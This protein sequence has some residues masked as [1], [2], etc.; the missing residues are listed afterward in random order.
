MFVTIL[1]HDNYYW[2]KTVKMNAGNKRENNERPDR[3]LSKKMRQMIRFG[4]RR[5]RKMND[6]EKLLD[7]VTWGDKMKVM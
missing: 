2:Q 6:D 1:A 7:L 4:A 3:A 5:K